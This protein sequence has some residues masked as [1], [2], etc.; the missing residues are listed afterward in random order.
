MAPCT[1]DPA[2]AVPA[3]TVPPWLEA[4]PLVL[5]PGPVVIPVC[6][7]VPV[8]ELEAPL[9]E[10]DD[11]PAVEVELARPVPVVAP[12]AEADGGALVPERSTGLTP[13]SAS[14]LEP[15][16]GLGPA[17]LTLVAPEGVVVDRGWTRPGRPV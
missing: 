5:E 8:A 2:D 17:A 1:V 16:L 6:D 7:D 3:A 13:V 11:E 10:D 9:V 12:G 15:P 4:P 14:K